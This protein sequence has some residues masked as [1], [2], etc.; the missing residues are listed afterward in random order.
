M[1]ISVAPRYC[2]KLE[3]DFVLDIKKGLVA[4]RRKATVNGEDDEI[5]A[6]HWLLRTLPWT[7]RPQPPTQPYSAHPSLIPENVL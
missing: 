6:L 7:P 5:R 2:K 4:K 3:V 1:V